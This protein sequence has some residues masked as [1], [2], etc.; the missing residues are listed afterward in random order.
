MKCNNS[1][2]NSNNLTSNNTELLELTHAI[3]G[4]DCELVS[5]SVDSGL[6]TALQL[7]HTSQ[8]AVFC[9]MKHE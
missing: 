1:Q 4:N 6:T 8:L 7:Y 3:R 5:V 9:K 2:T